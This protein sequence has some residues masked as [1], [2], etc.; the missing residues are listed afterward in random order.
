MFIHMTEVTRPNE[1]DQ[2]FVNMTK[3]M[4]T[5]NIIEFDWKLTIPLRTKRVGEYWNQAQEYFTHSYTE[6]P[7]VSLC[8]SVANNIPFNFWS[9]S[10]K[11]KKFILFWVMFIRQGSSWKNFGHLQLLR[12]VIVINFWSYS[13]G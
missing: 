11:G 13:K 1:Y 4:T 10:T 6:Y 2:N 7:W 12:F 5:I 3:I 9:Y 8:D